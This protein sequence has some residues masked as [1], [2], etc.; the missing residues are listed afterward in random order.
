M[1][2]PPYLRTQSDPRF[3]TTGA[4]M[5]NSE[6][7]DNWIYLHDLIDALETQVELSQGAVAYGIQEIAASDNWNGTSPTI[8]VDTSAGAITV[9]IPTALI[10]AGNR[11]TIYDGY[12]NASSNNITVEGQ[13]SEK[14]DGAASATISTNYGHL[15]L[16]CTSLTTQ[17]KMVSL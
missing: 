9:T 7:D 4:K 15:T 12:G 1:T 17:T 10:V 3:T 11:V 14:I 2:S 5:S 16:Q 8:E 6:L 13:A